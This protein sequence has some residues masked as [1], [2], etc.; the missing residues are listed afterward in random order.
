M[1]NAGIEILDENFIGGGGNWKVYTHN[2]DKEFIIKKRDG[3][4]SFSEDKNL[5]NYQAIKQIGLPTLSSFAV[6]FLKKYDKFVLV[7]ENLNSSENIIYV[8]PNSI[9]P[10]PEYQKEFLDENLEAVFRQMVEKERTNRIDSMP[11]AERYR[12]ENKLTQIVD[13]EV[14]CNSAIEDLKLASHKKVYISYDCYFIGSKKNSSISDLT[15]KLADFDDIEECCDLSFQ[16]IFDTNKGEFKRT[17][18][19][20]LQYFVCE[21]NIDNYLDYLGEL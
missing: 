17:M 21:M 14:F 18:T 15:Y 19:S 12:Y 4:G 6:E 9:R 2:L 13:F 5:E 3:F 10:L 11:V 1:N 20:F 7:G 8:S 16:K